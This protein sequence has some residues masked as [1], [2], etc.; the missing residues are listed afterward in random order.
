MYRLRAPSLKIFPK[1][2]IFQI[3]HCK[4]VNR[5]LSKFSLHS[6]TVLT[7]GYQIFTNYSGGLQSDPRNVRSTK[8]SIG[9][10]IWQSEEFCYSPVHLTRTPSLN[11]FTKWINFELRQ[12]KNANCHLDKI[13]LHYHTVIDH[14][15]TVV[16]QLFS[17]T[18]VGLPKCPINKII[19][20]QSHLRVWA[21]PWIPCVLSENSFSKSFLKVIKI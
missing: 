19:G 7:K 1:W 10:A 16:H 15:L 5:P 14:R 6:L 9:K 4:K 11:L 21:I 18:S 17:W 8:W 20:S 13:S 12:W 2:I 3:R